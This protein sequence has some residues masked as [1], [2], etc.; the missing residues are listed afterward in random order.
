MMPD[1]D[2][3]Y[4][5]VHIFPEWASFMMFVHDEWRDRRFLWMRSVHKG[6]TISRQWNLG[7][8]IEQWM[9]HRSSFS[10][11]LSFGDHS[12]RLFLDH[13]TAFRYR[14][15]KRFPGSECPCNA[16]QTFCRHAV[17]RTMMK[18]GRKGRR[19]YQGWWVFDAILNRWRTLCL[20]F[21]HV[22][23]PGHAFCYHFPCTFVRLKCCFSAR[24]TTR[25]HRGGSQTA[26]HEPIPSMEDSPSYCRCLRKECQTSC[27]TFLSKIVLQHRAVLSNALARLPIFEQIKPK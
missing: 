9:W 6:L 11:I 12:P 16:L 1:I 13:C 17:V 20:M 23:R 22:F 27:L 24:A 5:H 10:F 15:L 2:N 21:G 3:A 8:A 19:G 25:S 4:K 18:R 14:L 7:L 26:W